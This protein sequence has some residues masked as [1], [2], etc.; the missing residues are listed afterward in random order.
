MLIKTSFIN[1]SK[2]KEFEKKLI[3]IQFLYAFPNIRKIYNL[4]GKNAVVSR[5][6]KMCHVINIFFESFLGKV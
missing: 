1:H 6:Q 2:S 3:Q 4:W 5:T